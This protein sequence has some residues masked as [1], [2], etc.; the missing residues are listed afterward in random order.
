MS[1]VPVELPFLVELPTPIEPPL[2]SMSSQNN[3]EELKKPVCIQKQPN[4]KFSPKNKP[5]DTTTLP[6]N[7]PFPESFSIRVQLAIKNGSVAPERTQLI[8]D[9]GIFYYGLSSHP[10]QG[11]YKRIAILV[12]EKFPELR[13]SSQASYWVSI[14]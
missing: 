8:A 14:T 6:Q 1:L 4:P 3:N 2:P 12:C 5:A 11:D 7:L 10:K 9:V 13:D